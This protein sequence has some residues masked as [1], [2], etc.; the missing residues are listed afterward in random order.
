MIREI[1]LTNGYTASVE[2]DNLDDWEIFELVARYD[3][4]DGSAL[5]PL[6]TKILGQEGLEGLKAHL[7][8]KDGKVRASAVRDS[9]LE[10][11]KELKELKN[12]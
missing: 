8:K 9:V 2:T 11:F 6:V 10:I 7:K 3:A 4:G 1:T 12:S 5:P